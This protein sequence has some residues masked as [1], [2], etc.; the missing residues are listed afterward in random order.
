MRLLLDVNEG[1]SDECIVHMCIFIKNKYA[2]D[3]ECLG[4]NKS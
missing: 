3:I 4:E 2:I 1:E